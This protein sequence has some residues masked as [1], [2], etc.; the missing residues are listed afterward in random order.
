MC[1]FVKPGGVLFWGIHKCV[2]LGNLEVCKFRACEKV[3]VLG[4]LGMFSFGEPGS[5]KCV[6]LWSL[7]V[8]WFGVPEVCK[9]EKAGSV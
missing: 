1:R 5:R 7:E 6:G 9:F 2:E 4:N 3:K 8:C